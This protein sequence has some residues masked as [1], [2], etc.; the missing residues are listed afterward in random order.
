MDFTELLDFFRLPVSLAVGL[1]I[2]AYNFIKR[3]FELIA[4][5]SDHVVISRLLMAEKPLYYDDILSLTLKELPNGNAK[6]EIH[7]TDQHMN[8]HDLDHDIYLRILDF[9][10][11]HNL[12]FYEEN[13]M[14]VKEKVN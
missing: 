4:V 5:N 10:K 7:S 3:K 12:A 9:I 6:L 14:G 11:K 8:F 13:R 1:S 2:A